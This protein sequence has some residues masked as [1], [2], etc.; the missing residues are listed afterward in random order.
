MSTR[1]RVGVAHFLS[2]TF[3]M[4]EVSYPQYMFLT[5]PRN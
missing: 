1:K 5:R 4:L 3:E 2:R